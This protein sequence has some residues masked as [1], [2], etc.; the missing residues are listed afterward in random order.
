MR[1][2]SGAVVLT[3]VAILSGADRTATRVPEIQQAIAAEMA[4]LRVPGMSAA[5]AADL[6]PVWSQ[7]FGVAD[8]ENS[9]PARDATVY[10]LGSIAKTIT[11]VAVLQL[12]ERGKLD[13][14]APIRTY[15]PSFPPKP[16]PVTAR[17]L[18]AHLGGIR[19]YRSPAEVDNTQH[20]TDLLDELKLFQDEPLL[21]QP[22]TRFSYSTYGYSLLGAAVESASG[23]SFL[24]YLRQNIFAPAG[25]TAIRLDSVY[26]IVPHRARGYR[27]GRGGAIENCALADTSNKIPGGGLI[28]TAGDL[29]RFTASLERGQLL[30]RETLERMWT[31]QRTRDGQLTHYG[32]G[33]YVLD[34]GGRKWVCHT[35]AQQGASTVL[36]SS[37]RDGVAVALLANLEGIDL[38]PLAMRIAALLLPAQP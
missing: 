23:T 2:S 1:L 12:A 30:K 11:A 33:W 31:S 3:W 15:V 17:E 13:L 21:F 5:V 28:A 34:S 26:A 9:V 8:L 37:P 25:M 20:Y 22:G 19:H 29:V 35:G 16:W 14:D 36:L 7:G 10:R 6:H 4:R 18:L 27:V 38:A 24:D 32:L